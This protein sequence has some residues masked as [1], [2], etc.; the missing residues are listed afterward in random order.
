LLLY[1]LIKPAFIHLRHQVW[2]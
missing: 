2:L 1:I